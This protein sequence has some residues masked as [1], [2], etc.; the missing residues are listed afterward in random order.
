MNLETDTIVLD[1]VSVTRDGVA[2]LIG[3]GHRRIGILAEL[4]PGMG[5]DLASFL[6]QADPSEPDLRHYYPS[7]QRLSRLS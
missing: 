1:N 5:K 6:A 7:W 2:R 4:G 3:A